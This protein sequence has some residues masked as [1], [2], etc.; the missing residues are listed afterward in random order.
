M[1]ALQGTLVGRA[2]SEGLTRYCCREGL[3]VR[4]LQGTL[5]GTGWK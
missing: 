4:A 2:G 3:E 1:R 5:V